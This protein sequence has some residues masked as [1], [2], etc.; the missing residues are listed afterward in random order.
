MMGFALPLALMALPALALWYT[1]EG[2]GK[3]VE[4]PRVPPPIPVANLMPLPPV[5]RHGHKH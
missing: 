5:K 3:P 2:N 1:N 4:A